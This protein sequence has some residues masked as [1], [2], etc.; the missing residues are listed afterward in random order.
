VEQRK[1]LNFISMLQ[2]NLQ[3]QN[4][5]ELTVENV[6]SS[7][8]FIL[9]N[10]QKN[11]NSLFA[12]ESQFLKQAREL[13]E[14]TEPM[15]NPIQVLKNYLQFTSIENPKPVAEFE[16]TRCYINHIDSSSADPDDLDEA[17]DVVESKIFA[18]HQADEDL[19]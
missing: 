15:E 10:N 6:K 18:H 14:Q 5:S 19:L 3:Q 1:E 13:L 12:N 16:A 11:S 4:C 7:L 9:K 2:N 8:D 17:A